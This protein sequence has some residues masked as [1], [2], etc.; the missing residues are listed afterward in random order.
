MLLGPQIRVPSG[1]MATPFPVPEGGGY[2]TTQP[3]TDGGRI[4]RRGE[5]VWEPGYPDVD[6]WANTQLVSSRAAI[7]IGNFTGFIRRR[8]S[9][10]L[11]RATVR[12]PCICSTARF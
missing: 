7:R 10:T 3:A 1:A 9:C 4:R 8:A 6:T 12:S 5:I 11:A 2:T